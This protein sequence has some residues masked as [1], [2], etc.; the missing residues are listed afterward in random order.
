MIN[1]TDLY[2]PIT[3][4]PAHAQ[5]F[6][7]CKALRP[8]IR[9]FWGTV[10]PEDVAQNRGAPRSVSAGLPHSAPWPPPAEVIIPDTCMDIIMDID[11]EGRASTFFHGINDA[12]FEVPMNQEKAG[13]TRFA[14]RFHFWAVFYFAD[15]HMRESLNMRVE[16]DQY[17]NNFTRELGGLLIRHGS[18]RERVAAAE[19]YLLRRITSSVRTNDN[20]MNAVYAII[21]AKGVVTARELGVGTSL[22][23][24]QLERLFRETVGLSPKKAADLVRFQ[25]VWQ[26]LYQMPRQE[27]KLQELVHAYGFSDQAHF[28]NTFKKYAG[29]SPLAA[30]AAAGR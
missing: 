24:R 15:E 21:Q 27:L 11:E 28:N 14:I 6:Q 3:A 5:E 4:N 8:Y 18:F 19:A 22:S 30:L 23:Q 13:I 20:V 25:H 2:H 26:S 10:A 9:C 29:R 17:F 12:P 7:P 1:L 16:V